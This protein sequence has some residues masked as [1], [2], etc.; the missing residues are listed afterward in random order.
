MIII[1]V[2]LLPVVPRIPV[3]LAILCITIHYKDTFISNE[4]ILVS[5]YV[6]MISLFAKRN[7]C[8]NIKRNG[9]QKDDI[10]NFIKWKIKWKT[11]RKF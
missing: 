7:D 10:E 11:N 8:A 9:N 4:F 5:G 6:Y 1:K 2:F 3:P